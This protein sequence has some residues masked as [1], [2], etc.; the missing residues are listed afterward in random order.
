VEYWSWRG[1]QWVAQ[2]RVVLDDVKPVI[3]RVVEVDSTLCAFDLHTVLQHAFGWNDSHLHE[4]RPG[5]ATDTATWRGESW[6]VGLVVTDTNAPEVDLP[7]WIEALDEFEITVGQLF[8]LGRG[9]A[10][11]H[12]DFGDGWSHTMTLVE[13]LEPTQWSP[14]AQ[15]VQGTGPSGLDDVGG[16]GGLTQLLAELGDPAHHRHQK[17][18]EEFRFRQTATT[19][20]YLVP[21]QTVVSGEQDFQELNEA[22]QRH[23]GL[24]IPAFG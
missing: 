10:S 13:C 9:A 22:L 18:W 8:A 16:S 21:S 2:V 4:F 19:L 7:W 24:M 5:G 12:Y 6:E 1:P 11:Y 15:V 3:E 14:R 20:G 23:F 17:A